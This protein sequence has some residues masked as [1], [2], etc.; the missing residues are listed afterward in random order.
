MKDFFCLWF[1]LALGAIVVKGIRLV[2]RRRTE[3]V[4]RARREA[5]ER[6]ARP[7]RERAER[8]AAAKRT[9]EEGEQRR[10]DDARAACELLYA[11]HAPEVA[12]RLPKATF[13]QFLDRLLRSDLSADVVERKAEEIQKLVRSHLDSARGGRRAETVEQVQA[14]YDEQLGQLAGVKD[15]RLRQSFE[16]MLLQQ[17]HERMLRAMGD[18]A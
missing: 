11:Q 3:A 13:E 14:W 4:E 18:D 15:E 1:V 5:A 7:E 8:E 10:R 6:K 16:A 17:F 9:R 12:S 2:R